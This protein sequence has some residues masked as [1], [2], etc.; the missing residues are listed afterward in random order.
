MVIFAGWGAGDADCELEELSAAPHTSKTETAPAIPAIRALAGRNRMYGEKP[1]R[2][3]G[4]P[5]GENCCISTEWRSQTYHSVMCV[6]FKG[7]QQLY[8]H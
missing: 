2:L 6:T 8:F 3:G 7:N 4:L 1:A 5:S